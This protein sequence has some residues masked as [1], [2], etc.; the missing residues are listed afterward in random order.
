[1]ENNRSPRFPF[2]PLAEAIDALVK[3]DAAIQSGAAPNRA[4]FLE[5]LGYRSEHGGAM[6][7][8]A[9]LRG[10]HLIAP[11]PG[12]QPGIRVT[13]LGR[14]L[15]DAEKSASRLPQLRRAALSPP[16]FRRIWRK[17]RH[18][19]E[20]ELVELL[21][22]RGFT[23][24]GARRAAGVYRANSEFA[25]LED[26]NLEPDLPSQRESRGG[27]ER[28]L[29][30]QEMR[31]QRVAAALARDQAATE[32]AS[33]GVRSGP[34]TN[35]L[36]LPLSTGRAVIPSGISKEEFKM[37]MD[38]L[39]LWRPRLVKDFKAKPTEKES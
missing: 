17:A 29:Q 13:D 24:G 5:A 16:M 23:D 20:N 36:T 14:Q 35:A 30:R 38:T 28:Q 33:S 8:F 2:V 15:L 39:R 12:E 32:A 18:F 7:F 1:M 11:N 21:L 19:S 3:L 26:L 6:K 10:Y 27:P 25:K 34:P 37:L 22:L 9:A 31:Q 4:T